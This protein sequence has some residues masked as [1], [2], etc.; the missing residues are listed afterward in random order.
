MLVTYRPEYRGA[1]DRLPSSHRIA[2]APLDDSESR[3]LAAELLGADASVAAL[4][5]QIAG[6][7]AGNPFFAEEI[8]R[9][10]AERGVVEGT[11]GAYACRRDTSAD[12]RVPA[13][14]Q[15]TIAARIDRLAPTSK[16]TLNAA[17]VIGFRFETDCWRAWSTTLTS[18]S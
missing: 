4:I 3:A 8:V 14:L 13:S 18:T 9:D 16:R 5:D 17:A 10:L 1:L 12:V 2:L 11:P 7:A 6:R 15:A